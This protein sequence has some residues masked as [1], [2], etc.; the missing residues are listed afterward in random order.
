MGT[1]AETVG[2]RGTAQLA[3]DI[4]NNPPILEN[5]TSN[6]NTVSSTFDLTKYRRELVMLTILG[7]SG[8]LAYDYLK[9]N[10]E[11]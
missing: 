3:A 6:S 2:V 1:V 11:E 7:C 5:I 8:L 4:S 9:N 10:D